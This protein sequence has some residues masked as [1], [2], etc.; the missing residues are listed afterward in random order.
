MIADAETK[1]LIKANK[2]M[3]IMLGYACD[4]IVGLSIDDIHP[5]EDLPAIRESFEKQLRGEIS[6]AP[7]VP[8]LRKDGS[9]FYADINAAPVTLGGRQCLCWYL[10]RHHRQAETRRPASPGSE[11]GVDRHPCRRHCT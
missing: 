4:E 5:K 10:P 3:C 8:V 11:D 6:L 7:E 1:K 9:V 2:A